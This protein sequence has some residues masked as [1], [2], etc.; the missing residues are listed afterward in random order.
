MLRI[1][2]PF[3]G[4]KSPSGLEPCVAVMDLCELVAPMS[5]LCFLT[6]VSNI[7]FLTLVIN[8]YFVPDTKTGNV[9]R[10]NPKPVL[11]HN[12]MES[13]YGV[14]SSGTGLPRFHLVCASVCK[15]FGNSTIPYLQQQLHYFFPNIIHISKTEISSV[16]GEFDS[17]MQLQLSLFVE[18]YASK[19][20]LII[21]NGVKF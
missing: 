3:A 18:A 8:G 15:T 9:V 6:L 10:I 1:L 16:V 2:A 19:L 20:S 13:I 21:S 4:A 17:S 12:L 7:K 5:E 11:A 14:G